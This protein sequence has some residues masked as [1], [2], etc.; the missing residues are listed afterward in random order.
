MS[1]TIIIISLLLYTGVL[2]LL[3]KVLWD[4]MDLKKKI[5]QSE[6]EKGYLIFKRGFQMLET[7]LLLMENGVVT[8]PFVLSSK[9]TEMLY[10]ISRKVWDKGG[11]YDG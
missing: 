5:A 2:V 11:K 8:C 4:N 10:Q 1:D 7:V 9:E 6:A 3:C